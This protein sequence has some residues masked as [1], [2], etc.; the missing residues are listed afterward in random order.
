MSEWERIAALPRES[1]AAW[2]AAVSLLRDIGFAVPMLVRRRE[3]RLALLSP[4]QNDWATGYARA[5][6]D[7][8]DPF[9]RYCLSQAAPVPIGA[10]HLPRHAY[11]A[12][13]ERNLVIDGSDA[14]GCP[15]GLALTMRGLHRP[16]TMGLNLLAETDARGLAALVREHGLFLGVLAAALADRMTAH[17]AAR[18][19]SDRQRDCL[20]LVAEGWRTTRIAHRLGITEATVLMHLRDARKRLGATSR[21]HAVARAILSGEIEPG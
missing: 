12:P 8:S 3:G 16:D 5:V 10:A 2:D 13:A 15:A 7:G 19:L 21:D 4:L 14:T 18:V 6:A 9:V 20:A 17:T 11:L 1:D